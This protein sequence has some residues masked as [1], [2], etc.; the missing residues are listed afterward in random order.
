MLQKYIE[1]ITGVAVGS[2]HMSSIQM[3]GSKA[4]EIV[5]DS[6]W[7]VKTHAPIK[8]HSGPTFFANKMIVLVQNPLDVILNSLMWLVNS[9]FTNSAH[10]SEELWDYWITHCAKVMASW[11]D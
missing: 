3:M 1:L 11:F 9:D 6:V 10:F 5:D 8:V 2:D 7:V 4:E